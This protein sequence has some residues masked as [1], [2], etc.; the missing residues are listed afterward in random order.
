LP[1]ARRAAVTM[2]TTREEGT[3]PPAR[4]PDLDNNNTSNHQEADDNQH[5]TVDASLNGDGATYSAA[6]DKLDSDELDIHPDADNPQEVEV[7]KHAPNAAHNGDGPLSRLMARRQD[8]VSGELTVPEVEVDFSTL[9]LD[10]LKHT[11]REYTSVCYYNADRVFCSVVKTPSDAISFAQ[12]LEKTLGKKTD[13]WFGIN[14]VQGPEREN[15]GRGSADEVTRLAVLPADLD[16]K[17]GG[18]P[19]LETAYKIITDL[20][21]IL[22]F[23]PAAITRSGHG[24][25]PYW[26]VRETF[27]ILGKHNR[28]ALIRRWGRLVTS[29]ANK[30]GAGVDNIFDLPR[31]LRVPGTYNCKR[32]NGEE[33]IPISSHRPA[34]WEGTGQIDLDKLDHIFTCHGVREEP[35]DTRSRERVSDPDRWEYSKLTCPYVKTLIKGVPTDIPTGGRHQWMMSKQVRL[36]CAWRLGCITEEDLEHAQDLLYDRLLDLRMGEIV[37]DHEVFCALKY[38]IGVAACKT[39]DEAWDELG[40]NHNHPEV[41]EDSETAT[42]QDDAPGTTDLGYDPRERYGDVAALLNGT[43]P[44]PPQPVLLRRTDGHHLFYEGQVNTL[45]GNSEGGKTFI[46]LAACVEDLLAGKRVLFLDLDHNTMQAIV[47][48]MWAMGAPEEKLGDLNWFR[49]YEPLDRDDILT[50][51]RIAAQWLPHAVVVDSIGEMLPL[52]GASSDSA[53]DYTIANR[54]VLQPF[55]NLG[56]VVIGIDHP[57][58]NKAS[59]ALG[60]CGTIAKKRALGGVSLRVTATKQFDPAHGGEAELRVN[61]DRHG[62][63]RQHCLFGGHEQKAGTFVLGKRDMYGKTAWRVESP[64][65]T[66]NPQDKE[67]RYRKA[68][69]ELLQT[70]PTITADDVARH[71]SPDTT[72]DKAQRDQAAYYLTKMVDDDG[73]LEVFQSGGRGRGNPTR[74]RYPPNNPDSEHD[75]GFY[76]PTLK[77]ETPS[78]PNKSET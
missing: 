67:D 31:I 69:D 29:V 6:C 12:G 26:V 50:E 73:K 3:G 77:S 76:S 38:A 78:P 28:E 16:M 1:I 58:K 2:T 70:H 43:L 39:E 17:E 40:G 10:I 71:I 36:A 74:W 68:V 9:L 23:R 27:S 62:A 57:A 8:I 41:V 20:S 4:D 61:K 25:Q 22:H 75:L 7:K 21:M 24:L 55:A 47:S 60:P 35:E 45:F 56:A 59:S 37:P 19:D 54:D 5:T 65:A 63:V 15:A 66:G 72:P 11:D 48:R 64:I 13:T 18:C 34:E 14:P 52:L 46:A 53:D 49:Y 30:Y 33:P 42:G 44:E 32:L 51:V